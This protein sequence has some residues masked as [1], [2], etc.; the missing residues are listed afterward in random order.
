MLTSRYKQLFFWGILAL[1]MVAIIPLA[2]AGDYG[3]QDLTLGSQ[4][5]AV[6]Q[7]QKDL[8]D[9][10]FDTY[11]V[12]GWFGPKTY[13][14]VV[15]FQRFQKLR[16]DGVFGPITKAA[17]NAV[18]KEVNSAPRGSLTLGS[19]GSAVSQMQKDLTGLGFNTYG[20]DGWF[21]PK[22]YDAVVNFQKSRKL[23]QDGVFGP[24][25]KAALDTAL[26][27]V[28]SSKVSSGA[29]A[30]TAASISNYNTHEKPIV[31]SYRASFD[32]SLAQTLVGRAI[33]YMEYGYM[34]YGNTKYAATG[35]ID[36]SNFVSLVYS[37]FGYSITSAAKNYGSVGVKVQGVYAKKISGTSKYTLVG[38]EKLKPGDI[39]TFRNSAGTIGHVAIYMGLVNGNPCIINTC[40]GRPTAIGIVNSFSYWYGSSLM[41]VRRV[42]PASAYTA[43]SKIT[44]RGPV[45]PATYQVKPDKPII[46]PKNLSKGF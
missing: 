45:I 19:R 4:G 46:M 18:L 27:E 31:D 24:I 22:T 25:T 21:G 15:D 6:S 14:A 29:K 34:K 36:C 20:V 7:M 44:D 41:E 35:H 33:W 23:I 28:V 40:S 32:G 10:G 1:F 39:F 42:L 9:L 13:E 3:T 30:P 5:S 26:T 11:G 38:I 17:L 8:T 16:Q 43:G 37:D 2:Q 12:D